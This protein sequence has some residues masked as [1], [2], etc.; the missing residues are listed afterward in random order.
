MTE[1]S[2][3]PGDGDA[4][5]WVALLAAGGEGTPAGRDLPAGWQDDPPTPTSEAST[6]PD[7]TQGATAL[8]DL[9]SA[10]DH[11]RRGIRPGLTVWDA[12]EE[13]LRWWIADH[14]G[15]R[16]GAPD[17]TEPRWNDP[18]PLLSTL[19]ALDVATTTDPDDSRPV[20]PILTDAVTTWTQTHADAYNAGYAWPHP[21]S[22]RQFPPGTV[23]Q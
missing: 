1:R 2:S 12:V 4:D 21:A 8:L 14:N 9:V 17:Q 20:A 16:H 11:L 15:Q 10:V 22:R 7:D 5:K 6:A 13:A 18:D 23:Q 3:R 19:R